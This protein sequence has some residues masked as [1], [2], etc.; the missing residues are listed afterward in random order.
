M[1]LPMGGINASRFF[2][3]ALFSLAHLQEDK[4]VVD[5]IWWSDAEHTEILDKVVDFSASIDDIP[6]PAF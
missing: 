5:M 4:T 1:H 6:L 2:Q 3:P